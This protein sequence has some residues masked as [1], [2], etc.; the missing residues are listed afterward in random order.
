MSEQQT[1]KVVLRQKPLGLRS[2]NKDD[3]IREYDEQ[4]SNN[5]KASHG[6]DVKK[7]SPDEYVTVRA[8]FKRTGSIREYKVLKGTS[9]NEVVGQYARDTHRNAAK[10]RARVRNIDNGHRPHD[11]SPH[12][13]W[14]YDVLSGCCIS[15]SNIHPTS[16]PHKYNK[17]YARRTSP[18]C[19]DGQIVHFA[20]ASENRR[21]T[22]AAAT[23]NFGNWWWLSWIFGS[24]A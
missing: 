22:N 7:D 19:K 12:C 6:N 8:I 24:C 3:D 16:N 1:R 23:A 20:A 18:K 10:I 14:C 2:E 21:Y 15:S 5:N 11:I 17:N 13:C 9:V 4:I